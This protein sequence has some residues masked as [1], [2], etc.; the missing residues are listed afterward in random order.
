MRDGDSQIATGG[1]GIL[2]HGEG[3]YVEQRISMH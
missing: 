2:Y 3:G 1:R